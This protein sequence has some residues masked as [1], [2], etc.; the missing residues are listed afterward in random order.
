MMGNQH[1]ETVEIE[2]QVLTLFN[3]TWRASCGVLTG[4]VTLMP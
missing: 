2:G 3:L 1:G 4:T